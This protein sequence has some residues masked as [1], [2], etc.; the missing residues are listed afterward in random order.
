MQKAKRTQ[1]LGY[2]MNEQRRSPCDNYYSSTSK[3]D[4]D[5]NSSQGQIES[6]DDCLNTKTVTFREVMDVYYVDRLYQGQVDSYFYQE[7]D[8]Q[9]FRTEE[10][11]TC[12]RKARARKRQMK[13][14]LVDH[15]K[16]TTSSLRPTVEPP[17]GVAPAA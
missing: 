11:I 15:G 16:E 10:S 14:R 17:H 6:G 2:I 4:G 1:N 9:R 12:S 7:N 8:Y 13:R 5:S 3:T